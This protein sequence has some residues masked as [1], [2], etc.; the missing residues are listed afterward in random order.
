[1]VLFDVLIDPRIASGQKPIARAVL[2]QNER[3][4]SEIIPLQGK[5]NPEL[6]GSGP[7]ALSTPEVPRYAEMLGAVSQKIG[8]N[9][10]DFNAWRLRVEYPLYQSTFSMSWELP[11]PAPKASS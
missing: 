4:G 9:L 6:L 5:F 3:Y 10:T 7:A 8:L 11:K 2:G 1:V